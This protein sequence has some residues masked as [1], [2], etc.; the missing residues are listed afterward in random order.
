MNTTVD[1]AALCRFI[2]RF[3][4][5]PTIVAGDLIV[6]AY[7]SGVTSRVSREAPVLILR[8]Q[9]ER[10]APGGA[11]NAA[12]NL[13]DLGGDV[14][15]L[16]AVGADAG[17][18]ALRDELRRRGIG[19]E[20]VVVIPDRPTTTKMRILAGGHHTV[21]QQ[22]IRIDREADG[23]L[24]ATLQ[25]ELRERF[26]RRVRECAAVVI[27]DYGLGVVSADLIAAVNDLARADWSVP[28]VLVDSQTRFAL[29]RGVAS[30]TPNETEAAA[31]LS[32]PIPETEE[33]LER[34]GRELLGQTA[35]GSLLITRGSRGMSL[36]EPGNRRIDIAIF[37][38]AEIADVTGAGDTVI[39]A[40]TL[41]LAAGAS[42]R[43]A[44]A[45]A[46]VAAGLVVKKRGTATVSRGELL[47]A[48]RGAGRVPG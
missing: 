27:S 34:L 41:S 9:D 32:R 45:I 16:G 3:S 44:A 8:Y 30:L 18:E 24:P 10:L 4:G 46:N 48:M 17:G 5:I 29:F 38:D 43:E 23:P 37:G 7:L 36:F 47:E 20:D 33:D 2:D 14:C 26:L 19:V 15:V 31:A 21:S 35:A 22:V 6:D 13:R 25:Q 1:S 12:A 39:A 28:P 40:F 11:A 42:H